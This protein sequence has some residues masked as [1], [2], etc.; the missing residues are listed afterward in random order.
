MAVRASSSL[1]LLTSCSRNRARSSSAACLARISRFFAANA[2]DKGPA[3]VAQNIR[4]VALMVCNCVEGHFELWRGERRGERGE[5]R[6]GKYEERGARRR[7]ERRGEKREERREEKREEIGES[8]R[9]EERRE[10]RGE[11]GGEREEGRETARPYLGRLL[12]GFIAVLHVLHR[13]LP[14]AHQVLMRGP[15]KSQC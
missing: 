12:D 6:V 5:E 13:L 2:L 10:R 7:G 3:A 14:L 11:R 8:T 1:L 15:M 4:R 9:K